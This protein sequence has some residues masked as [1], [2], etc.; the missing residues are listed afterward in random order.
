[1]WQYIANSRRVPRYYRVDCSGSSLSTALT[2]A[3]RERMDIVRV[4]THSLTIIDPYSA[5]RDQNPVAA[6]LINNQLPPYSMYG[7]YWGWILDDQEESLNQC[8][9]NAGPASQTL[10]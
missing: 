5:V 10:D 6:D 2:L 8:W 7:I 1:M 4:R 9:L 3:R